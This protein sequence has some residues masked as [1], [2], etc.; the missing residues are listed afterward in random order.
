MLELEE[1]PILTEPPYTDKKIHNAFHQFYNGLVLLF[2]QDALEAAQLAS[3]PSAR[4]QFL[5]QSFTHLQT[6]LNKIDDKFALSLLSKNLYDDLEKYMSIYLFSSSVYQK[7]ITKFF[8]SITQKKF[9]K[10]KEIE[11]FLRIIGDK[12]D[13]VTM[14]TFA[15][16]QIIKEFKIRFEIYKGLEEPLKIYSSQTPEDQTQTQKAQKKSKNAN[17]FEKSKKTNQIPDYI[18]IFIQTDKELKL[19]F[20]KRHF[21]EQSEQSTVLGE[22]KTDFEEMLDYG[23]KKKTSIQS[24][25]IKRRAVARDVVIGKMAWSHHNEVVE[26][27]VNEYLRSVSLANDSPD[28]TMKLPVS[29]MIKEEELA[30]GG[31]DGRGS[32]EEGEE[33]VESIRDFLEIKGNLENGEVK[34]NFE[35]EGNGRESLRHLDSWEEPRVDAKTNRLKVGDKF[36]K[37]FKSYDLDKKPANYQKLNQTQTNLDQIINDNTNAI[38]KILSKYTINAESSKKTVKKKSLIIS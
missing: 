28:E 32:G 30:G 19:A 13:V 23:V 7:R 2:L 25:G 36:E 34:G 37:F 31:E 16:A 33:E 35:N 5:T 15:Y 9:S 22:L 1:T 27:G 10:S 18:L 14:Y 6:V 11:D 21:R 12:S 20:G 29:G 26:N 24:E 17:K 38:T 3:V 4:R 8:K